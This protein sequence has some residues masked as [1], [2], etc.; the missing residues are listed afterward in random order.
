MDEEFTGI[1]RTEA[2]GCS[3]E[4]IEQDIFDLK[5]KIQQ[6]FKRIQVRHRT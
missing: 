2:V 6:S 4:E 1:I 3:K 5:E